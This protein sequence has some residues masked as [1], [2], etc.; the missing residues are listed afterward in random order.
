MRRV[1]TPEIQKGIHLHQKM[2]NFTDSH[3]AVKEINTC[4]RPILRK[5][6]PVGSDLLIDFFLAHHWYRF[7]NCSYIDFCKDVYAQL[8]NCQDK[9]PKQVALRFQKMGEGQWLNTLPSSQSWSRILKNMDGRAQYKSNFSAMEKEIM[10]N[11]S[12][13]RQL[14]ERFYRDAMQTFPS[15]Y[16]RQQ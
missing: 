11:F 8:V 3:L 9:F 2:D 4:L 12:K 14:F 15:E 1:L 7:H 10:A 16:H 6:S 13:Y 5:Y